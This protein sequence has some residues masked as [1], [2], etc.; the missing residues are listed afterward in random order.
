VR[1]CYSSSCDSFEVA[2]DGEVGGAAAG[3]GAGNV[4]HLLTPTFLKETWRTGTQQ[5]A[6]T[7]WGTSFFDFQPQFDQAAHCPGPAGCIRLVP[8]PSIRKPNRQWI[9]SHVKR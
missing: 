5:V 8:S 9:A 6:S 7:D 4:S 1:Y 3:V 2:A